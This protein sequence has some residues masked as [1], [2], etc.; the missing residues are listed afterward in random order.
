[1]FVRFLALYAAFALAKGLEP[2]SP[3]RQVGRFSRFVRER[4]VPYENRTHSISLRARNSNHETDGTWMTSLII[5]R[6][7]GPSGDRH[8][9]A[10]DVLT[11]LPRPWTGRAL[12]MSYGRRWATGRSSP[13]KVERTCGARL[14]ARASGRTYTADLDP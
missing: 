5:S 14:V 13:P 12:P 8:R 2:S 9:S 3:T 6:E 1:M 10:R 11:V 7:M 4:G